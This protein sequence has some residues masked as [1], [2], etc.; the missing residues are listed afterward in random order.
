MRSLIALAL[1][2]SPR[3]ADGLALSLMPADPCGPF[4][5][6]IVEADTGAQAALY[7]AHCSVIPTVAQMVAYVPRHPT[8]FWDQPEPL[9]SPVPLPAAGWLMLA[10][11]GALAMKGRTP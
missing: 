6:V 10:A 3:H 9:P 4:A 5:P 1:L 11:L 7:A 2:A 8:R